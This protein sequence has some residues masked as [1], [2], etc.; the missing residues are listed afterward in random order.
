MRISCTT[1]SHT[2]LLQSSG[3]SLTP[4]LDLVPGRRCLCGTHVIIDPDPRNLAGDSFAV[5]RID[6]IA[7]DAWAA[8][9]PALV[10]W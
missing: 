9:N 3:R 6:S 4:A 1:A 8:A 10:T 5:A 2:W 7:A